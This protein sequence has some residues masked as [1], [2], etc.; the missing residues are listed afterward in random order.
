MPVCEANTLFVLA[1]NVQTLARSHTPSVLQ[2]SKKF[3]YD[4][5]LKLVY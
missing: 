3:S 5:D 4:N 2:P 1:K